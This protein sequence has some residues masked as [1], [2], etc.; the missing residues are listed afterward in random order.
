M[1]APPSSRESA[2][3]P[4]LAKFGFSQYGMK[5]VKSLTSTRRI[6]AACETAHISL[7]VWQPSAVA[8]TWMVKL[9]TERQKMSNAPLPFLPMAVTPPL[10]TT[11]DGSWPRPSTSV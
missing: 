9:E 6:G 5:V 8:T 11:A 4:P 3:K 2:T 10:M 7:P 1:S